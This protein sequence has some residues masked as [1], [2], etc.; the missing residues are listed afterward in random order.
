MVLMLTVNA[1]L[2]NVSK[3]KNPHIKREWS[4]DTPELIEKLVTPYEED[5]NVKIIRAVGDNLPASVR[6]ETTILEHMIKDD[7]LEQHYKKSLGAEVANEFLANMMKQIIHRYPHAKILEIGAGTGGATKAV[8]DTIEGAMSSYTYTDLSVGFF[9]LAEKMFEAYS[10]KMEFKTFDVEKSPK[11]QGYEPNSYDIVI[12]SNCLHATQSLQT[13]LEN[14]RQLLKPGGYL[15]ILELTMPIEVIRTNMIFGVLPGWWLGVD[16]GRKLSPTISRGAWHSIL[17]KTGFSGIDTINTDVS[18]ITWPASVVVSQA[19]DDRVQFLRRP[20]SAPSKSTPIYI[21]SLVILG[22]GTLEIA[23]V[24]EELQEHLQRFCGEVTILDSLPTEEDAFNLN[25]MSTFINLVDLDS[26]IFKDITEDNMEGVKRMSELAKNIL[27]VT[28]GALADEPYHMASIAFCRALRTEAPHVSLNN[29]DIADI[30]QDNIS[31]SI[32]EHLLQLYAL[33]EWEQEP[34]PLLWSKER[35]AFI[36]EGKLKIPRIVANTNLNARLNSSRRVVTKNLIEDSDKVSFSVPCDNSPASLVNLASIDDRESFIKVESSSAMALQVVPGTSLFVAIG[37]E[38]DSTE[39]PTVLLSTANTNK[40]SPVAEVAV[41]NSSNIASEKLLILVASELLATTMVGNLSSSDHLLVHCSKEDRLLVEALSRRVSDQNI[42]FSITYDSA[43]TIGEVKGPTWIKISDRTPRHFLRKTLR[44]A[45]PSH[46]LDLTAQ[47]GG[48]LGVR[49]SQ[50]LPAG[51]KRIDASTL[52]QPQSSLPLSYDQGTLEGRLENAVTSAIASSTV[53]EELQDLVIQLSQVEEPSTQYYATSAIRWPSDG[54]V[55]TRVRPL[56]VSGFFSKDKTYALIGLSG[57]IGQ[58][59]CEWMVSNGAGCVVLTSRRPDI[60][61]RWI[62]S[63]K[64]SGA[65]VKVLPM[66]V[67]D[68]ESVESAVKVIRETCPPIAGV[69]HGAMVL[70]DSLFARMSADKMQQIIGPKID[71]AI[72]LE[73]AFSEDELDFFVMFSSVSMV[74]GNAGQSLYAAG[75]GYLNGLARERRKRGLAGSTFDIGRVVGIGYVE[76]AAQVVRDQLIGLGLKPISEADLRNAFAETIRAGLPQPQDK[77]TLPESVVTMGVRHFREDEDVKG[78]WFT[79]PL[80][81]HCIIEKPSS[82]S[83]SGDQRK[84][85]SLPLSQQL[86]QVSS[87]KEALEVMIGKITFRNSQS[88]AKNHPDCF[89]EKLGVI[90]QLGDQ[91]VDHDAPLNELGID[92]LV[93]VEVRAWFLKELKV[94]IPVLKIIGGAS[95]TELCQKAL[96]LLPQAVLAGIDAPKAEVPKPVAKLDLKVPLQQKDEDSSS[97]SNASKANSTPG[98]MSPTIETPSTAQS[99]V[100]SEVGDGDV[101][102]AKSQKANAKADAFPP[103]RRPQKF[104]KSVPI[105]LAQSRYWFLQHLLADQSTHNV[106]TYY[107]ITGDLRVNDLTRAIRLVCSRHESL[108]TCFVAD[109]TAEGEASQKVMPSSPLR[110]EIK[111]IESEE[112]VAI[113]YAK[114]RSYELDLE[115]GDLLKLVLLT[116]SPSVHFLLM[117]YHHII[118]DGI[119]WQVFLADLQKAYNG[120]PLGA[121]PRQY[122]EFSVA[123]RKALESGAM[124][125]QLNYWRQT[126]PSSDPPTVLPL[127]PMARVSARKSMK[128]YDTHQVEFRLEPALLERVKSF[129]K[130]NGASPFH[131]Y[132]AAFKAMLFS[133]MDAPD[134]TIGVADAGRSEPNLQG[135]VGFF[136]NLLPLRFRRQD[137]Q[138]FTNAM[139]EARNIH[140]AALENSRIPFDVLLAELNVARSSSY[141]PIFQAFLDY[142][143]GFP[144][145]HPFGNTEF[146]IKTVNH[147]QSAYDITLDVTDSAVDTIVMIRAQKILYDMTATVLFSETFTHFLD[148]LTSDPSLSLKDTSLYSEKQ[149]NQA[150]Q[151]GCGPRLISEWPA[152]LPHR[153]DQVAEENADKIALSDGFGNELN[154]RD[155]KNR[156]EAIAEALK[157]KGVISGSRVPVFQQAASDWVCSMLAIMRVG[158]IYVPLD[159]RNPLPRLASV[160]KDCEPTAILAD[161]TTLHDVP[162]LGVDGAH[163]IDVTTVGYKASTP[164]TNSAQA[165]LPAAILY[166]SG[167]TGTPKGIVVTHSGLRNEIEGYTKMWKLG[168]E[169]TLQQSAFTFNHSSDQ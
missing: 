11:S 36:E 45:K 14:T 7:M 95:P 123:Q 13:T 167:S 67:T 92:S 113:E 52:F 106:A 86:A 63:F 35:E 163:V 154:Y 132:L 10:D 109:Q 145:K 51:C 8:L 118:M 20:L 28:Q 42:R 115:T 16:D 108:R 130:A 73:N 99:S 105:S 79:N 156:I 160:A 93:A 136:L 134:L 74:C 164:I 69:A 84:K 89:S 162:Q 23:R 94:D 72:N 112:D 62:D 124:D 125:E 26:P 122:P 127:L 9:G 131:L 40:Q 129:S 161:A 146:E 80:F 101:F 54:L 102:I 169:R 100:G 114:I 70:H 4:K 148:T 137:S 71:G 111:N 107:R 49:I 50:D 33:D 119:S 64:E 128:I 38:D 103:E 66:D 144:T 12:A 29:L 133:F 65:T 153:I 152:T 22:N 82:Q 116:L 150:I 53:D 117:N 37:K 126:F 55:K 39:N 56:D 141:S 17:R 81:S 6:G 78:P 88:Y 32:A 98:S 24:A 1:V 61:P 76:S 138:Q 5:G 77:D 143:Q 68:I 159:L 149:R 96:E 90:L 165:G 147:G 140:Y 31:K 157:T 2:L 142:R 155:M 44:I 57:A 21:E 139:V 34:Q 104:L 19:V 120:E 46:Y 18:P 158:A 121:P 59:L 15:L 25:P 87:K 3:G 166:T 60:D 135:S 30:Q 48:H 47:S 85:T 110:L 91:A 83:S 58:S 75:C 43:E 97:S 168:A 41:P 151:V 27:W